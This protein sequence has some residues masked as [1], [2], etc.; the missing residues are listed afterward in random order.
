MKK[1]MAALLAAAMMCALAACSGGGSGKTTQSPTGN[2]VGNNSP[3]P[4]VEPT[5]SQPVEET[6]KPAVE[7][8]A[9]GDTITL[10]F[11]EMTFTET[12]VAEDIRTTITT[13]NG[14]KITRTT[15]PE[16][17]SG[18]QFVYIKGTIKNLAT[19]ALPVYDFFE[20]NFKLDDYNFGV[21]ANECDV[22]T[23]EG[24]SIYEID[25]LSTGSFTL[26]AA[27]PNELVESHNSS[28]FTFGFYD[29]FDNEELARNRAFEDDPISMCPY[30]YT[31]DL[32]V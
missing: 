30:Q 25:P 29:L 14:V 5:E 27:I 26:Y 22:I 2:E 28:S 9:I 16:P 20:G 15:G 24:E 8:F 18:K 7:S 11:V 23:A 12:G 21:T 6:T 31:V 13:D 17:E 1:W 32:G 10:D 3:S 19:E 4:A